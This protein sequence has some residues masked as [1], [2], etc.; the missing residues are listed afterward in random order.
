M[1]GLFPEAASL[2]RVDA[3]LA[4]NGDAPA[5]LRRI[6]IEERDHLARALRVR[7]AQPA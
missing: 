4:A 1:R 3:W 5:A 7:A 2:D 6:V